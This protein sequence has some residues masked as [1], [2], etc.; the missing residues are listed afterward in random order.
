MMFCE[1]QNGSIISQSSG[2]TALDQHDLV[3]LKLFFNSNSWGGGVQ[4][5][6]LRTAAT[7]RP[8]VPAAGD[9]GHGEI[10]GM[11]IGKGNRSTR[12]KSAP[13]PHCRL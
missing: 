4:L 1:S 2:T 12:R 7:N 8:I 3:L 13:V 9:Y 5:G 6:P 10:G 11:M